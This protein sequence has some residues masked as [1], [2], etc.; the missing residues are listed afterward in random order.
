VLPAGSYGTVGNVTAGQTAITYDP[1]N[2]T[3]GGVRFH[4][5]FALQASPAMDAIENTIPGHDVVGP[6]TVTDASMTAKFG[7]DPGTTLTSATAQFKGNDV[8]R[9]LTGTN[10]PAGAVIK[11]VT[12][13]TQA[14]MS[15]PLLPIL[16]ATGAIPFPNASKAVSTTTPMFQASDVGMVLA[17]TGIPA[18]DTIATFTD[19]EHVTL[20]NA[21]TNTKAVSGDKLT[22]VRDWSAQTVTISHDV[23]S[24]GAM[25]ITWKNDVGSP[26]EPTLPTLTVT[27]KRKLPLVDTYTG[28]PTALTFAKATIAGAGGSAGTD[29]NGIAGGTIQDGS[30]GTDPFNLAVPAARDEIDKYIIAPGLT[31]FF[32]LQQNYGKASAGGLGSFVTGNI[33]ADLTTYATDAALATAVHNA[34]LNAP[35]TNG[36]VPGSFQLNFGTA[37]NLQSGGLVSVATAEGA[38]SAGLVVTAQ[39]PAID[40]VPNAIVTVDFGNVSGIGLGDKNLAGLNVQDS[41]PITNVS[42]VTPDNTRLFAGGTSFSNSW[43][44]GGPDPGSTVIASPGPGLYTIGWTFASRK[45]VNIPDTQV[46]GV[47][48]PGALVPDLSGIS[49]GTLLALGAI[50]GTAFPVDRSTCGVV[51]LLGLFCAADPNALG[52]SLAGICALF[53]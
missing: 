31:G 34:I 17:G 46:L 4:A 29:T 1:T 21:T 41:D 44:V 9:G 25:A 26:V 19:N 47:M 8:G 10:V 39:T 52:P 38:L 32:N 49:D 28:T 27:E 40:S 36:L 42:T 24:S 12:S 11:A 5:A 14:T 15:L 22:L 50:L 45:N 33:N 43:Q 48:Y 30:S 37:V 7:A 2:S 53:P 13:L 18:G 23:N 35:D 16:N 6:R 51:G 20:T 3:A